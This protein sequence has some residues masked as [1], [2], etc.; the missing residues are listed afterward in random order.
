MTDFPR[1]NLETYSNSEK[2]MNVGNPVPDS[3]EDLESQGIE[4]RRK[5]MEIA[6]N[7]VSAP[8]PPELMDDDIPLVVEVG[9]W[10]SF[11]QSKYSHGGVSDAGLGVPSQFPWRGFNHR[12]DE[13]PQLKPPAALP[14]ATPGFLSPRSS[15]AGSS[16]TTPHA[17][18][19]MPPNAGSLLNPL[20]DSSI[21]PISRTS[22][23]FEPP[24]RLTSW[25]PR[26]GKEDLGVSLV[27]GDHLP[28]IMSAPGQS[29][30]GPLAL[31]PP[32]KTDLLPNP[33]LRLDLRRGA[34]RAPRKRVEDFDSDQEARTPVSAPATPGS[35]LPVPSTTRTRRSRAQSIQGPSG[36]VRVE[37]SGAPTETPEA[38]VPRYRR[39]NTPVG[40]GRTKRATTTAGNPKVDPGG[41]KPPAEAMSSK[42][43]A[44]FAEPAPSTVGPVPQIA[45]GQIL[46]GQP[47]RD[48]SGRTVSDISPRE[49]S[50][51]FPKERLPSMAGGLIPNAPC[52]GGSSGP[53]PAVSALNRSPAPPGPEDNG[54]QPEPQGM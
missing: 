19:T 20:R 16:P 51:V 28:G 33:L 1:Q 34:F 42:P 7:R 47:L 27:R 46:P 11:S 18:A 2:R 40:M 15:L 37:G 38:K 23:S 6:S 39:P 10:S 43:E 12:V 25:S 21:E 48:V 32:Q 45:L 24:A 5:R 31:E 22:T 8:G 49:R 35:S 9:H 41:L 50:R 14:L 44:S 30:S 13:Q 4:E 17:F 36:P 52:P 53:L 54:Q 3:G 26:A 29:V